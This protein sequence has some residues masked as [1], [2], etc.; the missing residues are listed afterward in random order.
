MNEKE[1]N[2][3]ENRLHSWQPR[4]PSARIKR[5]LFPTTGAREAASL[6]LRWLAP[7]A[8]CLVLALTVASHDPGLSVNSARSEAMM[9]LISSN[10]SYTNILPSSGSPGRNGIS[11]PSFEWTN[12]SGF[13]SS[14]SPFSPGRIN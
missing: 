11:P 1:M 8:A 10:L 13:T 6:S 9:G 7:A 4:R 14:I 2:L 12:V 3:L 5:R